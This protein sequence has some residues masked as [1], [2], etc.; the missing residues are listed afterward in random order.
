MATSVARKAAEEG[1]TA[2]EAVATALAATS[3]STVTLGLML[4]LFGA[5]KLTRFVSYLPMPVVSSHT[6][7][8]LACSR[9]AVE[10][11]LPFATVRFGK[12]AEVVGQCP[13]ELVKTL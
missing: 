13:R 10:S 6:S 7:H 8:A 5:L 2:E 4:V 1:K 11:S 9:E 3:L 12:F